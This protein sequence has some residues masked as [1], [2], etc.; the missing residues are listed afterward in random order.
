M[1]RLLVLQGGVLLPAG[2]ALRIHLQLAEEQRSTAYRTQ[3]SLPE[4]LRGQDLSH[5][6][7]TFFGAES[8][9]SDSVVFGF[10]GGGAVD[11][12]GSGLSR[13][14]LPPGLEGL[15]AG[16]LGLRGEEAGA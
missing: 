3:M 12:A 8:G 10:L 11:G 5:P 16:A 13:C 14:F 2:L 4:H 6:F 9:A 1:R 7:G 15:G